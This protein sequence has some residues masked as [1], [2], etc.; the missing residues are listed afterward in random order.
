MIDNQ[1]M[2]TQFTFFKQFRKDND[3]KVL[4]FNFLPDNRFE[5]KELKN[6]DFDNNPFCSLSDEEVRSIEL[7]IKTK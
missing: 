2:P 7:V 4:Q 5:I 6:E 1:E 3:K